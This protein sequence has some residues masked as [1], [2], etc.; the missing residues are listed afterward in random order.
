MVECTAT[1][2]GIEFAVRAAPGSARPGVRG[3]HG[4]ALKVAVGALPERGRANAEIEALLA[5]WLDIRARAVRVV[6]GG[7][8]REKRVAVAGLTPAAFAARLAGTHPA[9]P[10][11]NVK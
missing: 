7:T 6:A 5:D 9:R 2:G 4:G 3:E 10:R 8:S 1:P 11:T